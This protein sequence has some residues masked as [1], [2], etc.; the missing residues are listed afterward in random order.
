[1]SEIEVISLKHFTDTI[2]PEH[3]NC[4]MDGETIEEIPHIERMICYDHDLDW[5]IKIEDR[6]SK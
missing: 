6:G 1:M 5:F 2:Y 3:E 4:N